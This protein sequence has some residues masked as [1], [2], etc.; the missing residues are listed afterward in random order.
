[1]AQNASLVFTVS[2]FGVFVS[3]YLNQVIR[4]SPEM[5]FSTALN[6]SKYSVATEPS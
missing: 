3:S 1:M 4:I 5:Y 2:V 6:N